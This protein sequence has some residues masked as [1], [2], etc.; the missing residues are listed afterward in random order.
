[1]FNIVCV[2]CFT[3][4]DFAFGAKIVR[5]ASA[6]YKYGWH[7]QLD[8]CVAQYHMDS[9]NIQRDFSYNLRTTQLHVYDTLTSSV[10]P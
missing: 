1:M 9:L 8:D 2:N 4:G 3:I 6:D 7:G 5:A 10:W